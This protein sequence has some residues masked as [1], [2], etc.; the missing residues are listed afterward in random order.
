MS[1]PNNL[2]LPN[3]RVAYMA[4]PKAANTAIKTELLRTEGRATNNPHAHNHF[5]YVG[6]EYLASRRDHIFIF[7]F[8]RNPYD[9]IESCWRDKVCGRRFHQPF[10]L[11]GI[12]SGMSFDDFIELVWET[13]DGRSEQHFRSQA[14]ELISGCQM[15]PHFIGRC[16]NMAEDWSSLGQKLREMGIATAAALPLQNESTGHDPGWTRKIRNMVTERYAAD[17]SNFGYEVLT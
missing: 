11:F 12:R 15:V 7:T 5:N 9:R 13:P 4:I 1:D 6:R 8:V 2:V 16:E 10:S 14:H 17:F 3:G